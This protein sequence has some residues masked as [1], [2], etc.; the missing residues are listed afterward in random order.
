[1]IDLLAGDYH[2]DVKLRH[3][4][5]NKV[6]MTFKRVAKGKREE[7]EKILFP[8]FDFHGCILTDE[9]TFYAEN[10]TEISDNDNFRITHYEMCGD[11]DIEFF[12]F[13]KCVGYVIGDGFRLKN[14]VKE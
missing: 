13:D 14:F 5:N 8:F 6:K 11:G 2:V 7:P 12:Y 4:K 1:M 3:L 10:V 9:F